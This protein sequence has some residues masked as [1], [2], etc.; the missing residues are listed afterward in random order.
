[1][2]DIQKALETQIRNIETRTGK[3]LDELKSLI[4]ASGLGKHA[5][6][7]AMLKCDLGLGHGDANTLAHL[8]RNA[9]KAPEA[10]AADPL[11]SLY[12]GAKAALRPIHEALLAQLDKLGEFESAPKQKYVSYRRKKQFVMIGPATNTRVD[13][14]LNIK[15]LP[16]SERLEKLP[17]GQMCSFRVKLSDVTQVDAVLAGWIKAAYEAAG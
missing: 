2:A 8:A 16:L 4:Q 11:D 17:A 9:A 5:E 7:V 15:E 13:L 12:S 6:I 10:P 3:T 1:M 14:G